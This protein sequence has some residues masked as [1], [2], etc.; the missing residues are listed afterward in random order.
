MTSKLFPKSKKFWEAVNRLRILRRRIRRAL[1]EGQPIYFPISG[2]VCKFG[3]NPV[4]QELQ[5]CPN[6]GADLTL[7]RK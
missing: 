7:Y 5:E 4:V 3:S 1:M 6:C 2:V